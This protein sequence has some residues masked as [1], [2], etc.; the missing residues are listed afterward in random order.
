MSFSILVCEF[1]IRKEL[2]LSAERNP[3]SAVKNPGKILRENG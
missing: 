3:L 1:N 2:K